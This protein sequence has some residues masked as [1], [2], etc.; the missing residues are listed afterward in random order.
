MKILLY[1][2]QD[3]QNICTITR[4]LENFGLKECFIYDK[5]NLIRDHY[6]KSYSRKIRTVSAGAFDKIQF[7]KIK[8][9]ILFLKEYTWRKIATIID[10]TSESIIWFDFQ[11][12]DLV[13]FWSES[14]GIPLEISSLCDKKIIIPQLWITQSLNLSHSVA[15]IVYEYIRKKGV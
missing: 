3:F 11:K 2:P 9:P 14:S 12:D 10:K 1:S 15:I 4:V 13:I 5:N 7:L 8:D 6:W